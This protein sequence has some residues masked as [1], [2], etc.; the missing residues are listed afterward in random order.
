MSIYDVYPNEL[1]EKVAEE[2]KKIEAIKPPAWATFA[3]TGA[4][5]ERAP[6]DANWWYVRAAAVLRSVFVL[7]PIGVSKLR[8]KYGGKKRRGHKMNEFRKGSGSVIRKVLQQL[9]KA[10]LIKSVEKGIHKGRVIAPKGKSLLDKTATAILKT[11]PK[12]AVKK[13]AAV[14]PKEKKIERPKAEAPKVGKSQQSSSEAETKEAAKV[15]KKPVAAKPVEAKKEEVKV[16]EKP[17]EEAEPEIKIKAI[18]EDKAEEA[19]KEE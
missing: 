2:L 13:P 7:G 15:E 1:I 8:T 19:K 5:K 12:R 6:S 11:K 9:E 16:E 18:E 4:H 14:K 17:K 3:K 10:E